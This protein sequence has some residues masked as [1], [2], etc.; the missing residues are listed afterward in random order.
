MP[1]DFSFWQASLYDKLRKRNLPVTHVTRKLEVK[2][3]SSAI[4]KTLKIKENDPVF[5][6]HSYGDTKKDQKIE[7]SI[8]TYRGDLNSFIIDLNIN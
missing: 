7:Y 3:A 8:A 2:K 6:F 1:K 4:S 5:Y